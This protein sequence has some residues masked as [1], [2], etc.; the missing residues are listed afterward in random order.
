MGGV[1]KNKEVSKTSSMLPGTEIRSKEIHRGKFW[2]WALPW[3]SEFIQ[4]LL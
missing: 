2:W 3:D 4:F 1:W